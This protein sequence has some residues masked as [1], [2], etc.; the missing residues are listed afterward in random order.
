VRQVPHYL[1]IGNGRI[2][3][4]FFHYME[5]SGFAV[6][7]WYRAMPLPAL[8]QSLASASHVLLL[9]SDDAIADFDA[10]H[11]ADFSGIKIHFSGSVVVSGVHGVHPLM[12][13]SQKLHDLSFYPSVPFVI[14]QEAPVFSELMPGFKNPYAR[15]KKNDKARYHAL[16]S[17]AGNFSCLLW[18]RMFSA[19]E[20]DFGFAPG[21]GV[22]YM[23]QQTENLATDY[24]RAL[25][26]PLVR[27]DQAT[28]QKHMSALADEPLWQKIYDD[29]VK[30]YQRDLGGA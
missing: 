7:R 24:A 16:V 17:M 29:F 15:I 14:E 26:G 25:T 19:F 1:I 23:K 11:L 22:P 27:G 8:R 12:T 3:R 4:H 18:Q 20:K 6:A 5:S 13:F 30:A 2:A 28:L 9:I 21:V 10:A